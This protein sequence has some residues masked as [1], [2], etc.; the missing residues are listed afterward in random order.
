MLGKMRLTILMLSTLVVAYAFVGLVTEKASAG[1]EAYRDLAV[2]TKVVDHVQQ[3]Y[4]EPPDM[5]RA[6][7]GA[8][9]GM[10]EA[11]DPFSSYVD[12]ETFARL[13]GADLSAGVG[14]SLSKRYGYAYVV[15]VDEGSPAERS[16]LRSGDLV[17][18]IDGNSTVLMSLWEA[19]QLLR[20]AAGTTVKLRLIRM[21]RS[22]PQELVLERVVLRSPG[23][24]ARLLEEGVGLLRIPD[25]ETGTAEAVEAKLKML[26]SSAVRGLVVDVRSAAHGNWEEAAAVSSLFLEPGLEIGRVQGQKGEPQ[27]MLS[28]GGPKIGGI[29]VVALVDGGTSGPAEV[30]AAA[31]KDHGVADIVGERT[32]GRG[33]IQQEFRLAEGDVLMIS[34]KLVYR[35]GGAPLQSEEPRKSGLSPDVAAPERDFISNFFFEQVSE[36]E[37]DE[38][39]D[40]GIYA[41]LD[42][43]VK[44]RQ[45]ELAVDHLKRKMSAEPEKID[46]KAA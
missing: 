19:Q 13:S 8:L 27:V 26:L 44:K 43:A 6:M 21:R 30:F 37:E 15:A 4:V 35:A 40:E 17:D 32:N 12:R 22:E 23:P 28:R 7:K 39:L 11:L 2:F 25:F 33:S 10:L 42:E 1:D 3:D 5:S 34:T 46:K 36:A 18:A 38:D 20:G 9:H 24:S 16:G 45:L 14:I 29:P 41:R 31:L